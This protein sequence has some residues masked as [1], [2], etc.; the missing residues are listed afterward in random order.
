M[1]LLTWRAFALLCGIH[2]LAASITEA[3]WGTS[4]PHERKLSHDEHQ[5][6]IKGVRAHQHAQLWVHPLHPK[7][8]L[9]T[10]ETLA[11]PHTHDYPHLP[12]HLSFSL[13]LHQDPAQ[14]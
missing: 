2:V 5:T 7:S 12:G 14:I 9:K 6:N 13:P 3:M 4:R 10:N 11:L 8:A 1:E